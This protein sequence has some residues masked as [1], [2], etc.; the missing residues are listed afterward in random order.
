MADGGLPD[1]KLKRSGPAVRT[2]LTDR[3]HL[4]AGRWIL[5]PM[6]DKYDLVVVGGTPGG[7][8]ATIRAAREGLSV[9]LTHYHAHLGG[10][11]SSGIGVLDTQYGGK[12]AP[13]HSEFCERLI[14]HYRDIYGADSEQLKICLYHGHSKLWELEKKRGEEPVDEV[15]E[16]D[17]AIL[18]NES[19]YTYGKMRFEAKVA[20]RIMNEM[21]AAEDRV[22]VRKNCYPAAV[23][24]AGRM[25]TAV[26]LEGQQGRQRVKARAFIDA[27]YEGDLMAVA[28]PPTGSAGRADRNSTR[29]MPVK[30]SRPSTLP[31]TRRSAIPAKRLRGS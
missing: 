3:L 4:D 2:L 30:S 1:L 11:L 28:G 22:E 18:P 26:F 7:V 8:A 31:M 6:K 10:L 25:I 24:R 20:E 16:R 29:S 14:D 9:L 15:N 13:I 12:R 27:S 5:K 17:T 23:D 21:I 19:A